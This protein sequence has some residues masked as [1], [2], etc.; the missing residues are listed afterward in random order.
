M[1]EKILQPCLQNIEERGR[2]RSLYGAELPKGSAAQKANL[3]HHFQSIPNHFLFQPYINI[4][5]ITKSL[6]ASKTIFAD[7][8]D[9]RLIKSSE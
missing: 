3:F 8:S 4:R 5:N 7:R 9:F 1:E 2:T 6:N